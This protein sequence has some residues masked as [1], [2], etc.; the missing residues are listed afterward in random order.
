ML[1]LGLTWDDLGGQQRYQLSLSAKPVNPTFN[2]RSIVQFRSIRQSR[3]T[4]LPD[5]YKLFAYTA[6]GNEYFSYI[7]HMTRTTKFVVVGSS[8]PK[9]PTR[10][11]FRLSI[12]E[13][14]P[15]VTDFFFASLKIRTVSHVLKSDLPTIRFVFWFSFVWCACGSGTCQFLHS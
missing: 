14:H 3:V 15:F 7:T 4:G 2:V 1:L 5:T 11:S 6:D 13:F 9:N 12:V 10:A 8:C